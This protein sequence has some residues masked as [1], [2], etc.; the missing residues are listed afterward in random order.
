LI[1]IPHRIDFHNTYLYDFFYFTKRHYDGL[2]FRSEKSLDQR[3]RELTLE[4]SNFGKDN[5]RKMMKRMAGKPA[6]IHVFK[7]N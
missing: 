2:F 6:E 4:T 7:M 3:K 5:H 1:L